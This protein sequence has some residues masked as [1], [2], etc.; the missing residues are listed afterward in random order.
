MATSP[1]AWWSRS[2]RGLSE[3]LA[4]VPG[5]LGGLVLGEERV[6]VEMPWEAPNSTIRLVCLLAASPY[7][8]SPTSRLIA[9]GASP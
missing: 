1:N 6:T 5:E 8:N 2:S 7:N 9:S 4:D 3:E